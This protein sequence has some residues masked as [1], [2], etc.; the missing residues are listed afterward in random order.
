VFSLTDLASAPGVLPLALS[1][2]AQ[3]AYYGWL[4]DMNDASPVLYG[5][6]LVI[7]LMI[8]GLVFNKVTDLVMLLIVGLK[9][10]LS[11]D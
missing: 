9:L 1:E 6:A 8:S 3:P 4:K 10:R 11:N 7:V 5:L 2:S